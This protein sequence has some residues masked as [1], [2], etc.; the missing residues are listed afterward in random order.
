M[1][2]LVLLS[3]QERYHL[4]MGVSVQKSVS[5]E[6]G[7]LEWQKKMV[8]VDAS[9][10]FW[11]GNVFVCIMLQEHKRA[12]PNMVSVHDQTQ[13]SSSIDLLEVGMGRST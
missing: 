9:Q 7:S 8:R 1:H 12:H 6:Q 13:E 10:S 3:L 4:F 2:T 11:T 5:R